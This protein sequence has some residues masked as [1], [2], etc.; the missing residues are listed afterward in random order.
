[1]TGIWEL[2]GNVVNTSHLW[3]RDN[4]AKNNKTCFFYVLYS[5]K[6]GGFDQSEQQGA[7][8][9]INNDKNGNDKFSFFHLYFKQYESARRWPLL[10]MEKS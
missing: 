3:Y 6:T 2:E 10:K 4:V 5:D 7:L 9:I 8:Y 1:M